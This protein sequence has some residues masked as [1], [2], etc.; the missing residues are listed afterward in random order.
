MGTK[1]QVKDSKTMFVFRQGQV[2]LRTKDGGASWQPLNATVKLFQYG[3]TYDGTISWTGNAL[4]LHGCDR[5]AIG[6]HERCTSVW[7]SLNDGD[8]W[9]DETGDIITNSPGSGVWFEKDFYLV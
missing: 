9:T 1:I 4:V 7:R 2:P 3:A 6:R 5:G 8:S